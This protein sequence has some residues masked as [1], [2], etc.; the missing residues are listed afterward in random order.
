MAVEYNKLCLQKLSKPEFIVLVL[1]EG[2][3]T[4]AIIDALGDELVI[5]NE[6]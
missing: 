2:D 1:S 6:N 5:M 3:E 4:Y